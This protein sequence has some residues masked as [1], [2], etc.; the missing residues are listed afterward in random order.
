VTGQDARRFT[1]DSALHYLSLDVLSLGYGQ[2]EAKAEPPIGDEG[3][4]QRLWSALGQGT[5]D[6]VTSEH[7]PCAPELRA[8]GDFV[9][10]WAG[11]AGVQFLLQGV[12]TEARRRGHGL[13]DLARWL[14]VNPA[15]LLG[16][17]ARK[18]HLRAGYDA[19]LVVWETDALIHPPHA[20]Y[21]RTQ[22]ASPYVNMSLHGR[23]EQ[24]IVGGTVAFER[25]A[26]TGSFCGA[27]LL[28]GSA[29]TSSP[30]WRG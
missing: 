26:H 7:A 25:G 28:S 1:C 27:V 18:G 14:S 13:A 17:A 9:S 15:R 2:T 29:R 20:E 21:H 16:L 4:K 10:A 8:D 6:L 12:W 19:D 23:V 24:T 3:S 5:I 30:R 22:G 11:V